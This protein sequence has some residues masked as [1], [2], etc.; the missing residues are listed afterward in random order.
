MNR[1][2][3]KIE[4]KMASEYVLQVENASKHFGEFHAVKNITFAIKSSEIMGFLGPNGAGKTTTIRMIMG[5]YPLEDETRISVFNDLISNKS[6]DYKRKIGFVPEISN[7]FSDLT[8]I[9]NIVFYGKIFGLKRNLIHDRAELLLTRYN[10]MDKKESI[11]KTLSK[12]L[13]QRLNFILALIHDPSLLILDEPTSGLDPLSIQLLR[14]NILK[15]RDEGK[16]ILI[17]THDLGEAQKLCDRILII[18]TGRLIADETPAQL[19]K[20]FDLPTQITFTTDPRLSKE[21]EGEFFKELSVT[22]RKQGYVLFCNNPLDVMG[23]LTEIQKLHSIAITNL[24]VEERSL[25]DIFF[26][27]IKTDE[28]I[29]KGKG[30]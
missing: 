29:Q 18:N 13:K 28:K 24:K 9:E 26:H 4:K 11:V 19:Q 7:A 20:R 1:S 10:L 6:H 3:G 17:T 5:I 27:I 23:Q 2:L 14:Q 15:L 16:S 22:S 8:V 21:K 30:K 12:G 25:E